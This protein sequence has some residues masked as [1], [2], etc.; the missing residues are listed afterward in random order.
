MKSRRLKGTYGLLNQ[1]QSRRVNQMDTQLYD[2]ASLT[3]WLT[4]VQNEPGWFTQKYILVTVTV[5]VAVATQKITIN[6]SICITCSIKFR[7][8]SA[9]GGKSCTDVAL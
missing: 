8:A 7:T 2:G 9:G 6:N 3:L 1:M 5:T 4:G